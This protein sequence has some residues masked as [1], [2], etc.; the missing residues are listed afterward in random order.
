[1]AGQYPQTGSQL[2]S[3]GG[4][5]RTGTALSTNIVIKVSG[6]PVGAIQSIEVNESRAIKM[7]DEVGT[8]GHIDSAPSSSTNISGSCQRTRFDKLRI[9]T[10]FSRG[11]IHVHAQ[12]KPFDIEIIDLWAGDENSSEAIVTIIKNVWIKDMSYSYQAQDFIIM[13]RMS[14]EAEAISSTFIANPTGNVISAIGSLGGR[15]IIVDKDAIEQEADRGGRR[16][17]LDAPGL[18]SSFGFPGDK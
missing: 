3:P 10:A 11:F 13:E 1:M 4:S 16:G 14:F 12:R 6:N 2:S 8:D 18:I 15:N 7:I 5:N 17:G 9:L